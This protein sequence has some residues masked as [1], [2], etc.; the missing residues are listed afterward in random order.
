MD[1]Y[2]RPAYRPR[3][4]YSQR[5]SSDLPQLLLFYILPFIVVNVLLF[6]LVTSVPKVTLE[7]EDTN[8]YLSTEATLK[9]DSWFPTR[10]IT[11]QM[12]DEELE[13]T[14]GSNRTYK[15]SIN[16]NGVL[17][18]TVTNL[19]GMTATV[20]QHIDILDD[21]PPSF[22]DASLDDDIL[23][24]HISD[25]QSTINFDGTY[26]IDS[27][28]QRR[29]PV[30]VDQNAGAVTFEMDLAGL[31]VF[32]MDRAGN[33]AAR[34]FTTHREGTVDV[35]EALAGEDEDTVSMEI[36]NAEAQSAGEETG[37]STSA[38]ASDEPDIVI[39]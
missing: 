7:V 2:S 5:S 22:L 18:A 38:P 4:R 29:V 27:T 15:I 19:N 10:S 28:G 3:N 37:G 36:E 13:T 39:E 25:S 35:L 24:L 8:D 16:R 17:K 34:S 12:D 6:F 33:E 9:L 14:K 11:V 1:R 26:A 23:T 31:Q 21:T 32:I 20:Y 30:T